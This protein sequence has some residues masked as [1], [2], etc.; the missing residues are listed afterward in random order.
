MYSACD[1]ID[2]TLENEPNFINDTTFGLDFN[3]LQDT[4]PQHQDDQNFLLSLLK[5]NQPNE[6][7]Q[8]SSTKRTRRLSCTNSILSS[9]S[10][11]SFS[12]ETPQTDSNQPND[13]DL[14]LSFSD[15][16]EYEA[17]LTDTTLN[18]NDLKAENS[19]ITESTQVKKIVSH[20]KR[21]MNPFMVWSQIERRRIKEFA[22]DIHNAE[23]SKH[24]G[25]KWKLMS[26]QERE[27]YI[28]EA[29]RLR[30][31][32]SQEH[33]D[34]KFRPKKKQKKISEV[35]TDLDL[36]Q[37]YQPLTPPEQPQQQQQQIV[38]IQPVSVQK[39]QIVE[40]SLKSLILNE[41]LI[42]QPKLIKIIKKPIVVSTSQL[43]GTS[44]VLT[45]VESIRKKVNQSKVVPVKITGLK[46]V[47]IQGDK[48]MLKI[49]SETLRRKKDNLI[50]IPV[51]LSVEPH[52][53]KLT[54]RTHQ[55]QNRAYLNSLIKTLNKQ[56]DYKSPEVNY[57]DLDLS[58]DWKLTDNFEIK[59]QIVKN[60]FVSVVKQE[61][62]LEKESDLVCLGSNP[63]ESDL[64]DFIFQ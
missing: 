60:D 55:T 29:E 40:N 26:K 19:Q 14:T 44:L 45:P 58:L 39:F 28:R 43:N 21:P 23:I 34:Y 4:A 35:H 1:L 62:F 51:V 16:N 53:R 9:C 5:T 49:R 25:A 50:Y 33:P 47:P 8:K 63:I 10:S 31:V 27:P 59:N 48:T 7:E 57:N 24:L 38:Q 37:N 20:I 12:L 54:I 61:E 13:D 3:L 11:S 56:E 64:F 15:L 36:F 52:S 22:P 42:C 18:L 30:Q 32:H 2:L 17:D 6:N 46:L 41:N